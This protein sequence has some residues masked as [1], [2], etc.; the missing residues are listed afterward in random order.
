MSKRDGAIS[1]I[2]AIFGGV[3]LTLGV[4]LLLVGIIGGIPS[5][6]KDIDTGSRSDIVLDAFLLMVLCCIGGCLACVG[7]NPIRNRKRLM[8][9]RAEI[10]ECEANLQIERQKNEYLYEMERLRIERENIPAVVQRKEEQ[11]RAEESDVGYVDGMEGHEFEYYCAKLLEKNGFIDVNVTRGSGDQ[12]VDIIAIKDDIKY[13]I[14]CKNYASK[15]GNTPIQEVSA[16]KVYYNCD[17]G[18]VLTN[19]TFTPGAIELAKANNIRLWDREVLQK[20]MTAASG[21]E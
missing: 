9:Q 17:V 3:V 14:Q 6:V 15:L 20:L 18:V 19:S 7:M 2:K 10:E 8:K 16:G 11:Q 1:T 5:L 12:G 13:A 4:F 21:K